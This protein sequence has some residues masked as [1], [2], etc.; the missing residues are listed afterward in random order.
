VKVVC[1]EHDVE[2]VHDDIRCQYVC[3]EDCTSVIND[4]DLDRLGKLRDE[5]EIR[6]TS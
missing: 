5:Q 6:V 2:M 4:E 1:G 3:L